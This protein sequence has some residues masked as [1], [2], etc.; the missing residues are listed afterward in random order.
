MLDRTILH[1]CSIRFIFTHVHRMGLGVQHVKGQLFVGFISM[2]VGL[3]ELFYIDVILVLYI[4]IE[5][6]EDSKD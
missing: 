4:S 3:P 5:Y 6:I 1:I 2:G